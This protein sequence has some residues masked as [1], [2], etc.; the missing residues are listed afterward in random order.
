MLQHLCYRIYAL[1]TV[2]QMVAYERLKTIENFKSLAL[3]VV[4]IAYGML[5]LTRGSEY[6]DLTLK[7]LRVFQN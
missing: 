3:K 6:S 4:A 2:C 5:L 7:L 1:F